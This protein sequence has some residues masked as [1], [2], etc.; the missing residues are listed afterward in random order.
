MNN[1]PKV[2]MQLLLLNPR[3]VDRKSNALPV[4]PPFRLIV[5]II[6]GDGG[7]GQQQSSSVDSPNE[8]G[9]HLQWLCI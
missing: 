5:I 7:C 4:A 1:L 2:V 8:P 9:E 3:P 6:N